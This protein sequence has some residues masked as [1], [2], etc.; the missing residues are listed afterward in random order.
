MPSSIDLYS[1]VLHIHVQWMS[2]KLLAHTISRE[3]VLKDDMLRILGSNTLI[4][5]AL[6][7]EM[8]KYII[9]PVKDTMIPH[10]KYFKQIFN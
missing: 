2:E 8:L 7:I 9:R 10:I 4:P 3:K 6:G 5:F 1:I